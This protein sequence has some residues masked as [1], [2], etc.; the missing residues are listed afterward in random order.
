MDIGE[1][2]SWDDQKSDELGG[3]NSWFLVIQ[4]ARHT[5]DSRHFIVEW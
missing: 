2:V 3:N 5:I 1:V 4:I